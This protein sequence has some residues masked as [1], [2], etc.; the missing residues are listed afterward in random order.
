M[1]PK[2][3]NSYYSVVQWATVRLM[4]I[5]QCIL[6][7][8]RQSIDFI[9]AFSQAYIPIGEAVFIELSKDFKSDGGKG[10]VVFRLKKSL[11]VQAKSARIWYEKLRN[12]FLE[13]SFVT[14]KVDSRLFMF[15]T[16]IC[17]VY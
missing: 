8:Q 13:R 10:D 4:L 1:S 14:S 9:N 17:I 6:G 16:V 3:L 15:M 12:G 7:L 5:L 11:Y 2:P